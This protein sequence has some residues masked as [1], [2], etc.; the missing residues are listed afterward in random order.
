MVQ[1]SG[2][3]RHV[4]HLLMHVR[5]GQKKQPS[6]A[7]PA[8]G[9]SAPAG[10]PSKDSVEVQK[11]F[12]GGY[13]PYHSHFPRTAHRSIVPEIDSNHAGKFGIARFDA[14]RRADCTSE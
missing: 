14:G 11:S 2:T 13:S 10:R 8:F 12:L 5:P 7:R 6:C 1:A 3:T 4:G 9:Q